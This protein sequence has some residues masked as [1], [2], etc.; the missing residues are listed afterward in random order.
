MI[1][2]TVQGRKAVRLHGTDITT[3]NAE[4]LVVA[5]YLDPNDPLWADKSLSASFRTVTHVGAE[6]RDTAKVSLDGTV[7]VPARILR[8]PAKHLYIGLSGTAAAGH[9]RGAHSGK[10]TAETNMVDV[11]PIRQGAGGAGFFG[12]HG[13]DCRPMLTSCNPGCESPMEQLHREIM[14]ALAEYEPHIRNLRAGATEHGAALDVLR[15][16]INVLQ[17]RDTHTHGNKST[18]DQIAGFATENDIQNLFK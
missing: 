4:S 11:G 15:Q 12:G 10:T 7:R 5:F 9:A 16:E 1:Q 3:G 17:G 6:T 2:I 13:V 8:E 14:A 18:I